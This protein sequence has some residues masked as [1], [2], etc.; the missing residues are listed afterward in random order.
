MN[1]NLCSS[2]SNLQVSSWLHR[3]GNN[4]AYLGGFCIYAASWFLCHWFLLGHR[5]NAVS[6]II[7]CF[8]GFIIWATWVPG[9]AVEK[10]QKVGSTLKFY[11]NIYDY[12]LGRK[13]YFIIFW[14][15]NTN[16]QKLITNISHLGRDAHRFFFS[17][18]QSY[19]YCAVSFHVIKTCMST[20]FLRLQNKN[21]KHVWLILEIIN[22]FTKTV[23][24]A[25]YLLRIR[26]YKCVDKK[27]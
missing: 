19:L 11:T 17:L 15:V 20:C 21:L 5:S 6:P 16:F 7:F 1:Q 24:W 9:Q 12:F 4:F 18:Y 23:T 27:H 25:N 26:N 10:L 3:N 22:S 2:N 8:W 13:Y 14:K